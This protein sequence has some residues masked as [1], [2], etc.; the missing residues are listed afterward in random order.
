MHNMF[1]L[2]TMFIFTLV[3]GTM[4]DEGTYYLFP[5][6]PYVLELNTPNEEFKLSK[7][8]P[9]S[10]EISHKDPYTQQWSAPKPLN[11][12]ASAGAGYAQVDLTQQNMA[13]GSHEEG[14]VYESWQ[15]NNDRQDYTAQP[16]TSYLPYTNEYTNASSPIT[17]GPPAQ[18][19]QQAVYSEPTMV[20]SNYEQVPQAVYAP[21][22]QQQYASEGMVF[23]L[24]GVAAA[25]GEGQKVAPVAGAVATDKA[26]S[27]K[28]G[29]EAADAASSKKKTSESSQE[30]GKKGD[31]KSSSSDSKKN[32]SSTKPKKKNSA[33]NILLFSYLGS[34]IIA[35][36]MTVIV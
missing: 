27:V 16:S 15:P 22:H 24:A 2:M 33:G 29:P 14:Q 34:A 32:T 23:G 36:L 20:Q 13:H 1:D 6:Q 25:T 30:K 17:F 18:N 12:E 26:T 28:S 21:P 5:T 9:S 31:K 19:Y 4:A 11:R 35:C 3:L 7:T 8:S 10:V